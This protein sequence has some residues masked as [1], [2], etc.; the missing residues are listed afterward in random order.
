MKYLKIIPFCIITFYSYAQKNTCACTT[1]QGVNSLSVEGIVIYKGTSKAL[2]HL[3]EINIVFENQSK[4]ALQIT[5]ILIGTTE[6]KPNLVLLM[7]TKNRKKTFKKTL[8]LNTLL[9][10]SV[11]LDDALF[12]DLLLDYKLNNTECSTEATVA[13]EKRIKK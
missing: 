13:Y 2:G 7:D 3:Y 12:A 6:I 1:K 5:N 4:C 9:V 11:G 10:P 8:Q